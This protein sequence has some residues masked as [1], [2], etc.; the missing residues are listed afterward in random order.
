MTVPIAREALPFA[1]P[2]VLI[3][4]LVALWQPWPAV[5]PLALLAFVLWFFRDPERRSPADP[6]A[7]LA[8][9]DGRVIRATGHEVSIFMNLFD[10]HVCRSPLSGRVVS[11]VHTPGRF[12]A[13][14]KNEA[15]DENERVTVELQGVTGNLGFTMIA[16]LI[17]RRIVC[18]VGEGQELAAGERVGMI[19]FGSRVDV[20]IP[21]EAGIRTKVGDRVVAGETVIARLPATG[22]ERGST[23]AF[24]V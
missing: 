6:D 7:V 10:V 1:V 19:R 23:K 17:A 21:E 11:Q 13:A 22:S 12:L 15:P 8:P 2:L 4:V 9:A 20:R 16:G 14:F 5:V 18:R 24:P 3:S